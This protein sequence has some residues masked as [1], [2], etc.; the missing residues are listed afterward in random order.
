MALMWCLCPPEMF[1]S[2]NTGLFILPSASLRGRGGA[3]LLQLRSG[4]RTWP[5]SLIAAAQMTPYWQ[6]NCVD[7]FPFSLA[8]RLERGLWAVNPTIPLSMQ[9]KWRFPASQSAHERAGRIETWLTASMCLQSRQAGAIVRQIVRDRFKLYRSKSRPD[10]L[11][12]LLLSWLMKK[13]K[14]KLWQQTFHSV[15]F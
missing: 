1:M 9:E 8:C 15:S 11:S 5:F 13:K 12:S 4:C 3:Q 10:V 14:K 6:N 2:C 7:Y